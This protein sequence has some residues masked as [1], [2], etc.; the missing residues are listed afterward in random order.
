MEYKY[1]KT[2][3]IFRR[4]PNLNGETY[5]SSITV[6]YPDQVISESLIKESSDFEE[7]KPVIVTT[8]DKVRITNPND[9][10]YLVS[11]K[12]FKTREIKADYINRNEY[13][14]DAYLV[15]ASYQARYE[16]IT[17]NKPLLSYK[18]VH[19]IMQRSPYGEWSINEAA[20]LNLIYSK[21]S[22]T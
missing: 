20:L 10:L 13:W 2:G 11:K 1:K 6:G 5:Y 8:E 16:Y 17:R 14:T 18:D 7:I 22:N 4:V 21:N 9:D 19:G 3:K 12:L 15:F